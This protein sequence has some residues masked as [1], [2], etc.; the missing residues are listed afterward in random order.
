MGPYPL[1]SE[2]FAPLY[3]LDETKRLPDVGNCALAKAL[4]KKVLGTILAD[5]YKTACHSNSA[6]MCVAR[7]F[8][9]FAQPAQG[10]TANSA[11][12]ACVVAD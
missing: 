5:D 12:P 7:M 3:K 4:K 10:S 11:L 2:L 6:D 1:F 9:Q 8:L